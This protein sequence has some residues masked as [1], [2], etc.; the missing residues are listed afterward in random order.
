MAHLW[1]T[2]LP[3]GDRVLVRPIEPRDRRR[4]AA[5]LDGLSDASRY[6]RFLAQ[7]QAFTEAELDYL[8]RVDHHDHEALVA[9]DPTTDELVG[10]ARYVRVGPT[11]AELAVTVT[12]AWQA[13]GIGT[14]LLDQLARRATRAGV[15]SFVALTL[16]GNAPAID[17]L[18][19]LGPTTCTRAGAHVRL[20]AEL[21]RPRRRRTVQRGRAAAARALRQTLRTVQAL[22]PG[23]P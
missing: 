9:I 13:R 19:R 1:T 21:P 11:V 3:D 12:D 16:A 17:L 18:S 15:R 14:L 23:A 5:I 7:R 8:T 6:Q 10:V 2:K 20:R 22:T 4:L